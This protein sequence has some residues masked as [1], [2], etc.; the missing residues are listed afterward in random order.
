MSGR[1]GR[2]CVDTIFGP[3]DIVVFQGLPHKVNRRCCHLVQQSEP[4][5]QVMEAQPTSGSSL[6]LRLQPQDPKGDWALVGHEI[7]SDL[8]DSDALHFAAAKGLCKQLTALLELKRHKVP[9]LRCSC[10]SRADAHP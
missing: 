10:V 8:L 6:L 3:G 5:V 2:A 1:K 7:S 4:S 9:C